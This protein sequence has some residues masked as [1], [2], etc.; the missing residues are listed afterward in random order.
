MDRLDVDTAVLRMLDHAS[1]PVGA[2]EIRNG[3]T[4]AGFELSEA[5]VSRRLRELDAR[6]VTEPVERKGRVLTED[7]RAQVRARLRGLEHTDLLGRAIDVRTGQDVLNLLRA[8]RAVEP[9]AVRGA[10]GFDA[11]VI[12]ALRQSL[13]EHR[14]ALEHGGP[15]PRQLVLDF[16]RTVT[17]ASANPLI[18]AMIRMA[19]DPALDHVE[20]AL[21][22]ILEARHTSAESIAEHARIVEALAAGEHDRAATVMTEHLDRLISETAAFID[23]YEPDLVDRLLASARKP[24]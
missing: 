2:R 3:L 6:G 12:D 21:D 15:I 1:G 14:R 5:T 7:G 13:A 4:Q 10:A 23:R 11:E 16:H 17:E 19:L 24:S 8:R 22:V 18:S 20:A 9:E